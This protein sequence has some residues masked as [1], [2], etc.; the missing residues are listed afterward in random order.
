[1]AVSYFCSLITPQHCPINSPRVCIK[2]CLNNLTDKI[3]TEPPL[4]WSNSMVLLKLFWH[5]WVQGTDEPKPLKK[6]IKH[7]VLQTSRPHVLLSNGMLILGWQ[8]VCLCRM[9][10][11]IINCMSKYLPK[12]LSQ[13]FLI[14]LSGPQCTILS[15]LTYQ[16]QHSYNCI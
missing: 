10:T 15:L 3:K 9:D 6:D 7:T 16:S 14:L 8:L 1:M 2:P 12:A 5:W 13:C 4:S 11:E